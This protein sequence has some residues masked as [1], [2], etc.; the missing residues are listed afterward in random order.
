M[1][2][3]TV[4]M[5]LA[6]LVSGAAFAQNNVTIYG[7][8]DMDYTYANQA[9][10]SGT[11]V[12][13]AINSGSQSTSRFGFMGR[14]DLGNGLEASFRM[15]G[16]F[17]PDTGA[18]NNGGRVMGR[19]STVG[20]ASKQWGEI[21]MGRRDGIHDEFLG[22]KIDATGGTT[23]A[24]I[25]SLYPNSNSYIR[26]RLTN[27]VVWLSPNWSGVELKAAY[28]SH[29]VEEDAANAQDWVP[30]ANAATTQAVTN[31]RV[32]VF[33]ATY[34]NGPLV[35][36]GTAEYTKQ[37]EVNN[38]NPN[39]PKAFDHGTIWQVGGGY[40]FGVVRVSSAYSKVNYAQNTGFPSSGTITGISRP[41]TRDNTGVWVLGL[42]AP[43][44]AAGKL[45][46]NYGQSKTGFIDPTRA[47]AKSS[48]FGILYSHELSK[49]TNLYTAYGHYHNNDAAKASAN[50]G[51][52]REVVS[53]G[54][55]NIG[56]YQQ[57]FQVGI[58]HKF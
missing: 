32:Y 30:V 20:L 54:M 9:I 37:Q 12:F 13:S 4:V 6:S 25:N 41:E 35:I 45:S 36:G 2:K 34:T 19:W 38:T 29:N 43:I 21:Q 56:T 51:G 3:K 16:G 23:V 50:D 48:M 10:V 31:R 49:R 26:D 42:S 22:Q 14:E 18:G 55:G 11:K 44:G 27:A 53:D 40:D 28:S 57:A 39:P 7:V 5:V 8:V 24:R 15:E 58:R 52:T 46:F 47:D 1:Q 17:A 33:G